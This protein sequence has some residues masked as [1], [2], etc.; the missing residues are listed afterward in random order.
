MVLFAFLDLEMFLT[1]LGL[2][3]SKVEITKRF[4]GRLGY[5]FKPE[6]HGQ[7]GLPHMATEIPLMPVEIY[8][9]MRILPSEDR[10]FIGVYVSDPDSPEV[11]KSELIHAFSGEDIGVLTTSSG[12]ATLRDPNGVLVRLFPKALTPRF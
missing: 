2:D 10:L 7:K 11:L 8:P 1:F 6:Q 9:P 4:Y 5:D 12:I 3:N